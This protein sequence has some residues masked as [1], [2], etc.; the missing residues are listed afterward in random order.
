MNTF[1]DPLAHVE[2]HMNSGASS[3]LN[4][5]RA[6]VLGANDGLVSVSSIVAGVAGASSSSSF[7]L[8]AGVAGLVAGALSMAVGEY[9]SVSTQRDTELALLAKER[10]ELI[11]QPEEELNELAAIYQ[12]KGLSRET[13]RIVATELTAHDAV[14]AHFDAELGLNPND[15]A[16]PHHAAYASGAAFFCGAVVPLIAIII[17]PASLRLPAVFAFG[18][19]GL[20][21]T[22]T[23]SAKVGGANKMTAAIRV[24]IGGILAMAITYGI[25]KIFGVL[26]V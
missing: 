22:G 23:L 12:G 25:G 6:A 19:A 17:A 20:V 15:L 7:I 13:A 4:W 8:T 2:T 21:V 10:K 18:I 1:R 26:G 11:D 9:V 5:L 3:K 16:N 14:A 24:V